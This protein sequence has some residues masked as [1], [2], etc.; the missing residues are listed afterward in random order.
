MAE[1]QIKISFADSFKAYFDFIDSEPRNNISYHFQYLE[2]L[3][4]I[5]EREKPVLTILSL[6]NKTIIIEMFVIIECLMHNLLSNLLVDIDSGSRLKINIKEQTSIHDLIG[7]LVYYRIFDN[8]MID[9]VYK[10]VNYRNCIHIKSQKKTQKAEYIAYTDSILGEC[11]TFFSNI[12]K[13]I[14]EKNSINYSQ[15]K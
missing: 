15:F 3:Y 14:W 2:F 8:G 10:L 7:Q 5:K 9:N 13:F 11:E 4:Q 1:D 12:L 6:T